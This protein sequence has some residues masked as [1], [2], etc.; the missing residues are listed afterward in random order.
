MPF[1]ERIDDLPAPIAEIVRVTDAAGGAVVAFSGDD[2]ILLA[3]HAQRQLMPCCDYGS[4]DTYSSLFWRLLDKG[5]T[6]NPVAK[7][8]PEKWLR[9]AIEVREN[10]PNLDWV[11]N[12]KWGKM[13]VSHFR[14]DNGVSVQARLDMKV[15]GLEHYFH[16]LETCTGVTRMLRL[17]QEI[18]GLEWALDSLGL[19]VALVD[20]TGSILHANSSFL[21]MLDLANGLLSVDGNGIGATDAC[22]DL[23]LRHAVQSVASGVVPAAYVPIRRVRQDPLIMAIS[24]G[25]SPG[26]AIIATARF[27]EDLSE[28]GAAV[29]QALGATPAEA[30]ALVGIGA[31]ETVAEFSDRHGLA[32]S[33]IYRRVDDA[34]KKLRKHSFAAPDLAGIASLVTGIAAITRAPNRRKH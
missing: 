14:L 21:E 34:K 9:R 17:R 4:K 6:G 29:R 18:R 31:G 5:M 30:E 24:A 8:I 20:R 11:N 2:R 25:Q 23:V 1:L 3:N 26:T 12:Y 16:G 32:P 28:V 22:D 10:S 27:G 15:A 7:E 19:A 13:L 33:T